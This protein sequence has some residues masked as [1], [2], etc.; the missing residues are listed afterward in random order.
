M[1]GNTTRFR[2]V[3]GSSGLQRALLWLS[4]VGFLALAQ[5]CTEP[6]FPRQEPRTQYEQYDELR[7]QHADRFVEDEFGRLK[8]NLRGRLSPKR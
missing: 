4:A 6:L 2:D 5:G 7:R 1:D 3:L 8:P